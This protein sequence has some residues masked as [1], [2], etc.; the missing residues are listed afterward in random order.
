MLNYG[1]PKNKIVFVKHKCHRKNVKF[2]GSVLDRQG[3]KSKTITRGH[4]PQIST[5]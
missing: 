5:S 1:W 3:D 2:S 4:K